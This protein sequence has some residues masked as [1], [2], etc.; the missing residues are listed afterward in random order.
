MH[1]TSGK[2]LGTGTLPLMWILFL[3][4]LLTEQSSV[5]DHSQML[6]SMATSWTWTGRR[7]RTSFWEHL[8]QIGWA[9]LRPAC[10]YAPNSMFKLRPL[11]CDLPG[12]STLEQL[13]IM[14]LTTIIKELSGSCFAYPSMW[15]HSIHPFCLPIIWKAGCWLSMRN[16]IQN[17]LEPWSWIP[18]H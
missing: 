6:G 7:E 8:M 5:T 9:W 12:S 16:Q 4:P 15:K 18:Y 17:L 11:K 10:F 2:N 14:G 13:S 1:F 3:N